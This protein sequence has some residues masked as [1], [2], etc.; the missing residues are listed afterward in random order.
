MFSLILVVQAHPQFRV[1]S[2]EKGFFGLFPEFK[3]SPKSAASP[4]AELV[5]EVS[6]WTPAAHEA[7]HVGRG[8]D[9]LQGSV[10][11]QSSAAPLGGP[12]RFLPGQSSTHAVRLGD[13]A[14]RWQAQDPGSEFWS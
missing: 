1:M 5:G 10:P 9:A 13:A 12:R 3:K 7:H 2:V 14:A 4:S 11:G 8:G 6:S